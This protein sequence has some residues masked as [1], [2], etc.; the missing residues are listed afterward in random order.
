MKGGCVEFLQSQV[1]ASE[2]IPT[3]VLQETR[4]KTRKVKTKS[5]CTM[6]T[7]EIRFSHNG[8]VSGNNQSHVSSSHSID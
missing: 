1:R 7:D 5:L 3:Q 4:E 8:I 2:V 6:K